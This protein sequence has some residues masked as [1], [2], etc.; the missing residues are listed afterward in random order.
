MFLIDPPVGLAECNRFKISLTLAL[1]LTLST[2]LSKLEVSP[3]KITQQQPAVWDKCSHDSLSCALPHVHDPVLDSPS[4][5]FLVNNVACLTVWCCIGL[6]WHHR[7]VVYLSGGTAQLVAK[8]LGSGKKGSVK[9]RSGRGR[10][11]ENSK[12]KESERKQTGSVVRG[13]GQREKKG[14]LRLVSHKPSQTLLITVGANL[15]NE[16]TDKQVE[17]TWRQVGH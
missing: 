3:L 15:V 8:E 12:D 9:Q 14:R 1:S 17:H 6:L 10:A 7:E 16:K 5:L 13:G 11:R 2:C 4:W